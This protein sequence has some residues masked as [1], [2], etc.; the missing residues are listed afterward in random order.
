[1]SE[2]PATDEQI[3]KW[4]ERFSLGQG[5]WAWPII[6]ALIR[7]IEVEQ[8][9]VGRWVVSSASAHAEVVARDALLERALPC[10]NPKL[11]IHATLRREIEATLP[12]ER[13]K[14]LDQMA[15]DTA[16]IIRDRLPEPAGD[17][18]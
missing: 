2:K 13:G 3:K 4:D 5:G 11:P 15:Q 14:A 12:T 17:E 8:G 16:A 10:L 1:M 6:G 7:R 9:K 18:E